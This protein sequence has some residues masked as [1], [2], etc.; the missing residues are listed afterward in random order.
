MFARCDN[1]HEKVK[2]DFRIVQDGNDWL[3]NYLKEDSRV[4]DVDMKDMSNLLSCEQPKFDSLSEEFITRLKQQDVGSLILKFVPSKEDD[5]EITF[6]VSAWR[7]QNACRLYLSRHERIHHLNLI[8]KPIPE[9]LQLNKN[10]YNKK[11]DNKQ[12]QNDNKQ[13]END[14]KQ[15]ENDSTNG[16][17]A[18]VSG[19]GSPISKKA[20]L[21]GQDENGAQI[22]NAAK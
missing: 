1:T 16:K 15:A 6:L 8:N 19:E 11:N 7:G 17:Q 14:N 2:C 18:E 4:V 3:M 5:I 21:S 10:T 22:E 12:A 20:K 9:Y 13:A